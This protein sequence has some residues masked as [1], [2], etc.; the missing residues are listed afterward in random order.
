MG[1]SIGIFRAKF[2]IGSVG[3]LRVGG[4]SMLAVPCAWFWVVI[5][6]G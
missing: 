6:M 4:M 5:K 1:C 3:G 2:G